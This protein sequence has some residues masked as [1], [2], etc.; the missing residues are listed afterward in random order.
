MHRNCRLCQS[1]ELITED[2]SNR[3]LL[4]DNYVEDQLPEDPIWTFVAQLTTQQKSAYDNGRE[5]ANVYVPTKIEI[6][7]NPEGKKVIEWK[8][9]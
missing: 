1:P 6:L 7:E 9:G 8:S 3:H 2:R 5:T 4:F